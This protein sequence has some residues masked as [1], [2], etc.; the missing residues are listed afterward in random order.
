M[1]D[2]KGLLLDHIDYTFEKEAWHLPLVMAV[3]GLTAEQAAWKSSL[4]RHS[5]WQIVR[6]IIHWKRGVLQSWAGD[7]PDYETL[8][9]DDWPEA[10]GDQAAWDAD[11][12]LLHELHREF[13]GLLEASDE[14][15]IQTALLAYRQSPQAIPIA[16]RLL[17]VFTHD[18]YHTGQI[19]YLRALQGIPADRWFAAAGAG[20]LARLRE[21]LAAQPELLNAHSRSGW[22]ALQLAAYLGHADTVRFLLDQ[23]AGVG[24]ASQ[25]NMANT[26]LHGAIAGKRTA[27][28]PLLLDH[29]AD[30]EATDASGNTALHLAAHEGVPE[31]VTMLLQ[32]GVRLNARR[33]DG[34][35]PLAVALREGRAA[36][37]ELLRKQGA[38]E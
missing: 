5:I 21:V 6:H 24:V 33:A 32:R 31:I 10:S 30:G 26:A 17:W 36:V 35:T 38:V 4:E 29:G 12:R 28:V 19:Q 37:A 18:A 8:E 2:V 16:R 9:R 3:Q 23:G 7:P 11:V 15:G 22:T 34:A 27:I 13:R 20:D 25:N 1:I 14:A